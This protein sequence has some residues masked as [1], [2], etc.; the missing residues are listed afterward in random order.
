MKPYQ[1][2]LGSTLVNDEDRYRT[3]MAQIKPGD[4]LIADGGHTCLDEGCAYEVDEDRDGR[5]IECRYGRHYL[6]N[7]SDGRG[8]VVGL[9]PASEVLPDE[10]FGKP[11][12]KLV[13][14]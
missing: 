8:T 10:D 7:Q 12:V 3:H 5:F 1:R 14:A 6:K 13:T 11:V 9:A 4:V 2:Y